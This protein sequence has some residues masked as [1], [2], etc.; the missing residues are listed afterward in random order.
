MKD[1]V[2]EITQMS[3]NGIQFLIREEG[4]ILKPYKDS[5]GIPTI[6]VGM[7][8]YPDSGRKVQ[9]TDPEL[10]ADRAIKYFREMLKIYELGV[11]AVT[12]DDITANQFD[13]LTSLTYNIG[14]AGFKAS[15]LLKRV[16]ANLNDPEI[17]K[18]FLAYS[19]A[20]IDGIKRPVLLGRRKREADL[21]FSKDVN[22]SLVQH[23]A[24]TNQ[25]KYMQSKLGLTPDGIFGLRT[26]AML[27]KFQK[28]HGLIADGIP[29]PQTLTK[30]NELYGTGTT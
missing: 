18:A 24:Y 22:G 11:Y 26:K 12:R 7:T 10:T 15:S 28:L 30:L 4:L 27:I 23:H 2:K 16:N 1:N 13:A 8:Y 14:V 25:V 17:A 9:M 6:G 19:N 5:V 29:G 20:R 21:Y 3:D